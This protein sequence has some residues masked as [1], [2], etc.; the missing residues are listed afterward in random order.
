[1][2]FLPGPE[3]R[4]TDP[5]PSINKQ[6]WQEKPG[7]LLFYDFFMLYIFEKLCKCTVP[8]LQKEMF[9]KTFLTF[10]KQFF[11][12]VLKVN[13]ENSRIQSR[14]RTNMSRI[15]NTAEELLLTSKKLSKSSCSVS[16]YLYLPHFL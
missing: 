8:Y 4:D 10:F 14:I 9:R 5:D 13:D 6:K 15:H 12:G 3:V 11:V 2:F 16:V 7:F 1:M